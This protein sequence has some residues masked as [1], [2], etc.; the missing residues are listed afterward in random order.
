MKWLNSYFGRIMKIDIIS[1]TVCPWCFIGKRKLQ[2]AIN[3][4][5]D[6]QFNIVW[7]PYQLNPD[8]PK[9]GMERKDYI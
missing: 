6:C 4:F 9:E 2:S 1:D 5:S 3:Y 8:M 7:R